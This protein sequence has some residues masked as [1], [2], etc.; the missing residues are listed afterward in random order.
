MLINRISTIEIS[1]D[2][3]STNSTTTTS[4]VTPIR[5]IFKNVNEAIDLAEKTFLETESKR[6]RANEPDV[7]KAISELKQWSDDSVQKT[8]FSEMD[9][10]VKKMFIEKYMIEFNSSESYKKMEKALSDYHEDSERIQ[11]LFDE[12]SEKQRKAQNNV[13]I[14]KI[15][16]AVANYNAVYK[17]VFGKQSHA[18]ASRTN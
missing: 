6:K 10:A 18:A 12:F 1:T 7:S 5:D 13:E 4:I 11:T 3:S 8:V 16:N 9:R 2:P 15:R 17:R 14:D